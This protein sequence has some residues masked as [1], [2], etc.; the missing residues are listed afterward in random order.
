VRARKRQAASFVGLLECGKVLRWIAN[1]EKHALAQYRDGAAAPLDPLKPPL[2]DLDQ[3]AMQ[4]DRK[5]VSLVDHLG[6]DI[7]AQHDIVAPTLDRQGVV[8]VATVALKNRSRRIEAGIDPQEATKRGQRQL[9]AF[10]IER[11]RQI[12]VIQA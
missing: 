4:A 1:R 6:A 12:D 7:A 2:G 8:V 10:W 5:Q 9:E 3:S 11:L